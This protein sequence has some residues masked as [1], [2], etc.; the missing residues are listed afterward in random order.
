[1]FVTLYKA[2]L[3]SFESVDD[4]LRCGKVKLVCATIQIKGPPIVSV[5]KDKVFELL[6]AHFS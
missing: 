1:M 5:S 6:K 2:A 3:V 4:I